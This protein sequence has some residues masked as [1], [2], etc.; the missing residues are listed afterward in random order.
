M[1]LNV[2]STFAIKLNFE[3]VFATDLK[4]HGNKIYLRLSLN[5]EII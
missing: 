4:H 5:Y 1:K 3:R 2:K